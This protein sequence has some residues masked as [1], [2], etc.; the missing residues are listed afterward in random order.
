M[1]SHENTQ[2]E[3]IMDGATDADEQEK[4]K[5]RDE[6]AKADAQRNDDLADSLRSVRAT[7]ENL[8][9]DGADSEH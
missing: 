3:P 4:A 5:G 7:G 6:H 8:T 1:T 2:D 9:G